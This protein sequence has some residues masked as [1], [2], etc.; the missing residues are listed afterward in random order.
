MTRQN[1]WL[2]ST[3]EGTLLPETVSI[4][5]VAP[6]HRKLL[7]LAW[8]QSV[9]YT[10]TGVWPL[11]DID[12]FMAV[13]G[14]KVDVW[15]VRTVGA[16]LAVTGLVLGR[17]ARRKTIPSELVM[18]AAGQAGVLAVVDIVYVSVGRISP[19]YLAD[20]L[21]ELVLIALWIAWCPRESK[22]GQMPPAI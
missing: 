5:D 19:I 14:P 6:N 2:G 15:L 12:S 21:P 16:L 17:A 7:T 20:S 9:F 3:S 18:I 8:I 4:P 10:T 22:S 13:T 11:L 1:R